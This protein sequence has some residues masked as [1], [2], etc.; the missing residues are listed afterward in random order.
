MDLGGGEALWQSYQRLTGSLGGSLG[1]V[2]NVQQGEQGGSK[3]VNVLKQ[4]E[5]EALSLLMS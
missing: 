3:P 2:I 1:R 5:R 4:G